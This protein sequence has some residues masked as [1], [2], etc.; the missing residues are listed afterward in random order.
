[1]RLPPDHPAIAFCDAMVEGARDMASINEDLLTLGRRG[2][3]DHAPTDLNTMVR[4]ALE[5]LGPMPD[6]LSIQ[7]DLASDLMPVSGS[8]PQLQR[9]VINLLMNAREA[10]GD[11]GTVTV[12]TANTYLDEPGGHYARIDIGT[13]VTLAVEDNGPGI[14][15]EI[16]NRIFD[17]F[18]TTKV[19]GKRRGSGL[20]LSVVE[21]IVEDHDGHV[22]YESEPGKGTRFT[23]YFPPSRE[24]VADRTP[25]QVRGGD[26]TILVVDDDAGARELTRELLT[27][28]GYEVLTAMSGEE[29]LATLKRHPADLLILDMVM[30]DGIDGTET[31]RRALVIRP[32]QRAI[33][34]SGFAEGDRADQARVLGVATF[35]RKPVRLEILAQAVRAALDAGADSGGV[36]ATR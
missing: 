2:H 12:R 4:G 18:F 5:R 32:D 3:F 16:G 6:T 8:T 20:G 10:M 22:D 29:A 19:A 7:L 35:L 23:L 1:M 14:R 25:D 36:G 17:V 34:L 26:E 27:A 9:A 15:P 28:L 11:I 33:V 24:A 21:A 13:H 31:Y 30:P